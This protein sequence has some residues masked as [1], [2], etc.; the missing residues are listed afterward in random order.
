MNAVQSDIEALVRAEL[1]EANKTNPPFHSTHEGYAVILEESDE[2][3]MELV[4]L[5]NEIS[6]LWKAVKENNHPSGQAHT[7]ILKKCAVDLAC[8]A[9]QVA[10]MCDKLLAFYTQG[11]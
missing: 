3:N 9:V 8:E 1:W 2:V 6:A 11:D 7:A 4:K 10:A 5:E